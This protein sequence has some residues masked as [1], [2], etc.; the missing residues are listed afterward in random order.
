VPAALLLA[1]ALPARAQSNA[2]EEILRKAIALHQAGNIDG[3]IQ[4]YKKYLE[5]RPDSPIALSNLG[6]AY[7][8]IARYSDA[9]AQYRHAL[10][11]QPANA[12]VELNLGL[13]YYKTGQ[14][15]LAAELLE[16]VHRAAPEQLQPTLLLADCWLAMGMDEKVVGLLAPLSD[17]KPDDLAI[18][19]LFGTALVRNKQIDRGQIVIDR[20]LHN[21]DSA[22]ARLLLGTTKLNA[23][24]YPAALIDLAEAVKL[25][26]GLPDV[27]SF[28]GQ[29]LLRT[30]DAA[31]ATAAFRKGLAANPNDFTANL[32]LAVLLRDDE[33]IEEAAACLQR[34]LQVRPGD[35]G[36]RYQMATLDLR[37][38]R[39]DAARR[40]LESIVREA[41]RFTEAHVT[42]ATVY[43][44]LKLKEDGDR[45][46]AIVQKLNAET[47]VKQQQGINIK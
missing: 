23:H 20:I 26:P 15:E 1:C 16:K 44:R 30:G 35:L 33:K 32:Q 29:A 10:R 36:V 38:Q 13:A 37:Q 11:L 24:D 28:Y 21:G 25:N 14:A 31:G 45:E 8:R 19:Y 18:A 22:E 43:Y 6:A 9:I 2:S 42:L 39:L 40:A 41:P 27:Y 3:A 12:P 47:Q 46:R 34:A 5:E 4:A 17:Q 7:A